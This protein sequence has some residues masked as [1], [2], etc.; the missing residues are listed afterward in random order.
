MRVDDLSLPTM[1]AMS[2]VALLAVGPPPNMYVVTAGA[3]DKKLR[4][5]FKTKILKRLTRRKSTWWSYSRME[6]LVQPGIF[7]GA[8]PS[9]LWPKVRNLVPLWLWIKAWSS[10]IIQR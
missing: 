2:L 8:L 9:G 1:H 3:T 5:A 7:P 4:I 10:R 6:S